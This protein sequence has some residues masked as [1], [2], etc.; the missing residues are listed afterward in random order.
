MLQRHIRIFLKRRQVEKYTKAAIVLQKYVRGFLAKKELQRLKWLEEAR[1]RS[2][3]VLII[4]NWWR[5]V[6]VRKNYLKMITAILT[7]QSFFRGYQAR[8]QLAEQNRAATVLQRRWRTMLQ[9]RREQ[10]L[11]DIRLMAAITLQSHI[12]CWIERRK[13]VAY[14]KQV[15]KVQA[16][17]RSKQELRKF[18]LMKT[19]VIS[20][21]Q[22]WRGCVEARK[23][24]KEF[25][26]KK[27]AA[28]K[29]QSF[30]RMVA[31]RKRFLQIR[32]AIILLQ[33]GFRGQKERQCF[34]SKMA[35]IVKIQLWWRSVQFTKSVQAEYLVTRRKVVLIQS[36]VRKYLL[37]KRFKSTRNSAI[38]IQKHIRGHLER[39]KF[40]ELQNAT[41]KV[42]KYW[43]SY[44]ISCQMRQ[45]FLLQKSSICSRVTLPTLVTFGTPDPFAIPAAIF[46]R[47][48]SGGLFLIKS[49]VRSL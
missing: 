21:Q 8:Q 49:N 37:Q 3:S 25:L 6:L 34:E 39:K 29:L 47:A 43:R 7:I 15:I 18:S 45:H 12:R 33:A 16:L 26:V 36:L 31:E 11:A 48:A 10:R 41:I 27:E 42:Q 46:K 4:Q 44:Q 38:T 1:K 13:Y 23:V 17:V 32:T 35:A 24:Q 30:V 40:L 22:W 14:R 19:S 20:I 9:T 2:C 5:S 28:V